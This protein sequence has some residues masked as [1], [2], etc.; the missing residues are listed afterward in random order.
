MF[1]DQAA[2]MKLPPHNNDFPV[3]TVCPNNEPQNVEED[4]GLTE[5][6]CPVCK[7][8]FVFIYKT[9]TWIPE[10]EFEEGLAKNPPK[11]TG[12]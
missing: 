6:T 4:I 5:S 11:V 10:S 1:M 3:G 7:T 2:Q 9:K 12:L 8:R